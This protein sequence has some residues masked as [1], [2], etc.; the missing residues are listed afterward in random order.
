MKTR[1]NEIMACP[2]LPE[3][4]PEALA[5]GVKHRKYK[6]VSIADL[7]VVG[8]LHKL[9]AEAAKSFFEMRRAAEGEGVILS[10]SSAFR[11]IAK[12]KGIVARKLKKGIGKKEVYKFSAP[13]GFSEHHTG[14]VIDFYPIDMRFEKSE[15]FKWLQLHAGQYGWQMS[16][17]RNN[18]D[19]VSFE[20]WHWRFIG[21]SKAKETF[22]WL[23]CNQ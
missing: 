19:G 6:E 8:S 18:A 10:I 16:F 17:P 11:T 9:H 23:F 5:L 13:A 3:Y 1:N 22:N 15:A 4:S 2:S 7:I 21:G 12:Q 20:P 14:L